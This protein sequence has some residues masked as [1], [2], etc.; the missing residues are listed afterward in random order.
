MP[1]TRNLGA[2]VLAVWLSAPYP[3][4][5]DC[6]WVL[7]ARVD[8]QEWSVSSAYGT[9]QA[10]DRA[11][12]AQ[13]DHLRGRP[14]VAVVGSAVLLPPGSDGKRLT[15]TYVCAPD[16]IDPRGPKPRSR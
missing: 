2:L 11:F 7:W 4:E 8:T 3:A 12:H 10:C 13:L 15:I 14:G 5:A 6:A 9:E 1:L 16:T